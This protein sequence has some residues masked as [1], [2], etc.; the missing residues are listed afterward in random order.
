MNGARATFGRCAVIGAAWLAIAFLVL[1]MLV[2]FPVSLTDRYFLSLPQERLSLDH[3]GNFFRSAEWLSATWQ[4]FAIGVSASVLAMATGSLCAIGCWRLSSRASE[5]VRAL[6]LTPIIVPAIVHALAFNRAW[7]ELDLLDSYPGVILAHALIGMPYVVIT[8]ST[9]LANFDPRL[10]QAARGLGA[11]M[12][13]TVRHVIVPAIKPGVLSGGAIAFAISFDDIVV[14]LFI[15]SRHIYTLPKRIWNGIQD[16]LDPTIAVVAS[17]LIA[18]TFAIV[19]TKH[20]V[21]K[22]WHA[23]HGIGDAGR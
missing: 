12:W 20:M 13:Q 9:S 11:S 3:Y 5:V 14:V 18:I 22:H 2:V 10:E 8:V 1:P 6:M 16:H 7:V 4:S 23:R 19:I 15:T 21:E 17:L